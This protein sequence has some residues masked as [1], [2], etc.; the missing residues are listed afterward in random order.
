MLLPPPSLSN[1]TVHVWRTKNHVKK[2]TDDS[3]GSHW[4][5]P[6]RSSSWCSYR[7]TMMFGFFWR[8]LCS[9]AVRTHHIHLFGLN[10]STGA[11][12][13][14]G[15]YLLEPLQPMSWIEYI[16]PSVLGQECLGL[17][18]VCGFFFSS[19]NCRRWMFL[20]NTNICNMNPNSQLEREFL[21]NCS[22]RELCFWKICFFSPGTWGLLSTL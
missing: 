17:H 10:F 15:Y 2:K 16:L 14:E 6:A 18:S 11:R 4:W 5:S 13:E 22:Q 1:I 9:L 3:T 7:Q 19:W 21:L 8:K 20:I 12:H